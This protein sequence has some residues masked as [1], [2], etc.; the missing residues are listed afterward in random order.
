MIIRGWN[1]LSSNPAHGEVYLYDK[2]CQ[3]LTII[4]TDISNKSCQCRKAD[5]WVNYTHGDE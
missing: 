3:W 5:Y 4:N 2:V 1:G